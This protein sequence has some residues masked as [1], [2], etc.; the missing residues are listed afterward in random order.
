MVQNETHGMPEV[1][2]KTEFARRLEYVRTKI[3]EEE[4]LKDS[5]RA[6]WSELVEDPD[7]AAFSYEAVRRYHYKT[8]EPP[9]RYLNRVVEVF[10]RFRLEWL[11]SGEGPP[12]EEEYAEQLRRRYGLPDRPL[13]EVVEQQHPWLGQMTVGVQQTFLDVLTAL[14]RQAAGGALARLEDE[15]PEL[16]V[17]EERLQIADDLV[18]LLTLPLRAWGVPF[19]EM[20]REEATVRM[21]FPPVHDVDGYLRQMLGALATAMDAPGAAPGDSIDERPASLVASIRRA[22]EAGALPEPTEEERDRADR[23]QRAVEERRRALEERLEGE[24][25]VDV[26]SVL[27]S[28]PDGEPPSPRT[29]EEA[30]EGARRELRVAEEEGDYPPDEIERLEEE[31]ER[32]EARAE[33][34]D[35][36]NRD[37][38]EDDSG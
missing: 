21:D 27:A 2:A 32:L 23:V 11:V 13:L 28:D 26:E 18:L 25:G 6:F 24:G 9:L 16:D 4:G 15:E 19:P 33:E 30:L 12:T 34:T 29:V 5:L 22:I 31:I 35:D 37:E 17:R 20:L 14:E 10:P 36:A 8:R 7:D 3:V 1:E 38:E